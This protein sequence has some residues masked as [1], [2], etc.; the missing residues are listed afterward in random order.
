[1][2][3]AQGPGS[4]GHRDAARQNSGRRRNGR[5]RVSPL[6]NRTRHPG[7][8]WIDIPYGKILKTNGCLGQ[9]V[10]AT[11][12]FVAGHEWAEVVTD[13]FVTTKSATGWASA[14]TATSQEQEVG[15]LCQPQPGGGNTFTLKLSTGSFTMQKLWSNIAGIKGK[16]V[17][18][19]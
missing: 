14:A 12:S 18:G 1:M 4:S 9:S 2:V 17:A 16:C 15:D 13:P 19:S 7:L 3:S 10:P 6:D 8:H 11:L 5:L